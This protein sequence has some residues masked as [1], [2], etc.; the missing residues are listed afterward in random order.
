MFFGRLD[1]Q[2]KNER[3]KNVTMEMLWHGSPK[4]LGK[5]EYAL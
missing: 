5:Y 1:F 3:L 2:D 4:N